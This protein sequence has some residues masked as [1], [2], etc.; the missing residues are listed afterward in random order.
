M[1]FGCE[2]W[3]WPVRRRG[4][5]LAHVGQEADLE[6]GA[7]RALATPAGGSG[8]LAAPQ[9]VLLRPKWPSFPPRSVTTCTSQGTLEAL[10]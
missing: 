4:R 8:A 9:G 1:D 7:H 3:D 6:G 10:W 2:M 5:K